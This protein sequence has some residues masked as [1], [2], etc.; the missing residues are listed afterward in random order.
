MP[1]PITLDMLRQA[2]RVNDHC[3]DINPTGDCKVSLKTVCDQI[4]LD[5]D[6][7]YHVAEQR[8]YRQLF[9]SIKGRPVPDMFHLSPA[10]ALIC[11]NLAAMNLDG[12]VIGARAAQLDDKDVWH[13]TNAMPAAKQPDPLDKIRDALG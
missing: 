1:K 9:L 3:A 7:V 5:F 6:A 2:A 4:G 8:A 11:V 13:P 10:D 12:I